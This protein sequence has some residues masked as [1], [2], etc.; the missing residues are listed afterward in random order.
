MGKIAQIAKNLAPQKPENLYTRLFSERDFDLYE[1]RKNWEEQGKK[2]EENRRN[3]IRE[4][5]KYGGPEAVFQFAEKV[6]SPYKVG[7]SLGFVAEVEVDALIL[8]NFLEAENTKKAIICNRIY[9]GKV[10]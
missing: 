1:D 7:F 6:D 2:L 8:P 9:L 5:I 3:A 10:L 4:I